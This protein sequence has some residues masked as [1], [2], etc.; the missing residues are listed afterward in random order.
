MP[1]ERSAG[2]ESPNRRDTFF[3]GATTLHN[4]R[5]ISLL[6]KIE[7]RKQSRR[8]RSHDNRTVFEWVSSNDG[9]IKRDGAPRVDIRNPLF[10]EPSLRV[11]RKVN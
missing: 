1:F 9:I 11:R 7:S 10:D 5:P 3:D 8:T 2:I 4:Q 6:R